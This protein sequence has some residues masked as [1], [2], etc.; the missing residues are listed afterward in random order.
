MSAKYCKRYEAVFLC[1]HPKGPKLSAKQTAKYIRKD[2]SFVRKWCR[3]FS[4]QKNVDDL[5]DRGKTRKTILKQDKVIVKLFENNPG[6]TLR[7]AKRKLAEKDINISMFTIRKRLLEN[8]IR[9][10]ST[11][12][13]PLLSKKHCEKRLHWAQEQLG[14]DWTDVVFTDESSFWI[15]PTIRRAWSKN[16][17]RF[18]VRTV[19][20]PAKL[21][22]W[23]CFNSR[24]FGRLIL[25]TGIL[26]AQRMVNLYKTGLLK[27][28][29][30]WFGAGNRNWVLQEDN[31][32][33][34]RS[35]LCVAW[36]NE[37]S[38]ISM[39]WPSQSPDANPIENVWGLMK[40][41]LQGIQIHNTKQLASRLKK[42]WKNLSIDYAEKL[43]DSMDK[44]CGAIIDNG[45]DFIKY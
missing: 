42:I 43:V 24:G 34:H 28:T 11:L 17:N 7:A 2:E 31:D 22:V 30:K 15:Y 12:A 39:Q 26:N 1:R 9:Y 20:H 16:N 33:K 29:D 32:P 40:A 35:R 18:I 13:K 3:R 36:K 8:K 19:K 6:M 45:G 27:S 44:R 38:I 23:G 14:R 37:N 5:P 4:E 21:H 10:R 25:F 41:K